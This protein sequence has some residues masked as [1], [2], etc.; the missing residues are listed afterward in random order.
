M[1]SLKDLRQRG[2]F[3][4]C[5]FKDDFQSETCKLSDLSGIYISMSSIICDYIL[6]LG[7][8]PFLLLQEA[9]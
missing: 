4:P 1:K 3:K 9:T 2:N 5:E 8:Q 7:V 6:E